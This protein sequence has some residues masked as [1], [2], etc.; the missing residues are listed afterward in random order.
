MLITVY[1]LGDIK[2]VIVGGLAELFAGAI[3]IGLGQWL[4]CKSDRS[5]YNTA[6]ERQ[7]KEIN[8]DPRRAGRH[9]EKVFRGEYGWGAD[10]V[11][12]GLAEVRANPELMLKVCLLSSFVSVLE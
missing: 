2:V 6:L 1:R 10:V 8:E 7:R 11:E 12:Q 3:S 5:L 4:A 9:A